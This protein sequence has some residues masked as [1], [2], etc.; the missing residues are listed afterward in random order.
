MIS[1][2]AVLQDLHDVENL[3]FGFDKHEM[4]LAT[5]TLR[6]AISGGSHIENGLSI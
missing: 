3:R 5:L 4:L 1:A 2:P 6:A